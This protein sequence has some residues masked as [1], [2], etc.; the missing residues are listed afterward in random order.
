MLASIQIRGAY[1][2]C[3]GLGGVG[4]GWGG[5]GGGG[6]GEGRRCHDTPLC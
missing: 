3:G 5:G 1:T 2:R 6:L 4:V